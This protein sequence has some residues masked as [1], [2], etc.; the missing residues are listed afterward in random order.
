MRF[1]TRLG[2]AT[3]AAFGV[4]IVVACGDESSTA[5]DAG[6]GGSGADATGTIVTD[7]SSTSTP[8]DDGA[9][10]PPGDAATPEVRDQE[11]R[12]RDQVTAQ[13]TQV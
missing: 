9:A 10:P 5:D 11:A 13:K 7:D 2:L 4:A 8:G 6:D 12:L 3:A 1:R